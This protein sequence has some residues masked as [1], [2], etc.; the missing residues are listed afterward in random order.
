MK[1]IDK[2]LKILNTNRNTFVTFIL[3]MFSFYFAID[4]IVEMLLMIFTGM[5]VSYWNPLMYT[6]AL[7]CPVFAFMFS[8]SSSFASS[9]TTK[10]TLF[11]IYIIGLYIIA[12]SMFIQWFNLGLLMGL[13][14]LPFFDEIVTKFPDLIQPA[15][16][17]IAAYLP[18]VT[19]YPTIKWLYL[20][21]NDSAAW[22]RSIWEYSGINLTD[23]KKP[24]GNYSC[25]LYMFNDKENGQ[26][27]TFSEESRYNSLFVCGG[28]GSGKTALIF[29]PFIAR[30]LE[31]KY[32]FSEIAKEMG[33][34]ALKTG[35]ANLRYPYTNDYLNDHFSLNMLVPAQGKEDLF[36]AYMKKMI[37]S[38]NPYYTYKDIGIT[39]IAPD[40][41][42]ISH[43]IEVCKN[44]KIKYNLIDPNSSDSLGLNPFVYSDPSKISNTISSVLKG[45]YNNAHSEV[46]DAY[47]EDV[48]LQ[49]IENLSI[50]L[51]EM[52]PRLHNGALPN[53]ED[54]LKL[55]TNFDLVEKMCEILKSDQELAE[56]YSVQLAYFKKYFYK[57]GSV[58]NETEKDV[59]SAITQLDTL[60]R[61][62]GVKSVLCNR[63]NNINFDNM[64]QNGEITFVC[65]RR[66]DLGAS[67]HK[68][69]G[70]FFL[71]SMQNAVLSRPGNERTRVPNFLYI[72]EFADFIGKSTEPLFTMYRKYRVATTISVQNL[73]QLDTPTTK[74]NYRN[75]ILSN[76]PSKIFTGSAIPSDLDWWAT[77]F[78]KIRAWTFSNNMDMSKMEYDSKYGNVKYDWESYF[79]AGKLANL[80]LKS[81]AFRIKKD[82][83]LFTVGEGAVNFID[84]KYKTEKNPK[85]Y[86]FTRFSSGIA[87]T[88]EDNEKSKTKFD[89]KHI[90][91]TDER[92]EINPVQTDISDSEFIFDNEDAVIF[93]LKKNENKN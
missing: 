8:P 40:F 45:M 25:D 20:G 28:S 2:F 66:G 87:E 33:Y 42:T 12:L 80:P 52:Y 39:Y 36:K 63:Y 93:N 84:S 1:Y 58:R 62:P 65:T 72:D 71:L 91:F 83:G 47:R 18:L 85:K 44:F 46:E 23:A 53:I 48:T 49:A 73:A 17:A 77:E 82:N 68:A 38:T 54:M 24:N 76:C 7:A 9:R 55:L 79:P 67:S 56:K 57:N 92:D 74:E 37:I 34:T 5:S 15:F 88:S 90:D 89:F 26:K 41:E 64:L 13:A 51:K 32:F 60:L 30:D 21:V 86:D 14:S 35:I 78:G 22:K 10:V 19:I 59:F 4:R 11:Y 6:F 16:G 50:L 31:K 75:I 3:T 29:E 69:F 61:L 27:I 43:E 81:C 70:L